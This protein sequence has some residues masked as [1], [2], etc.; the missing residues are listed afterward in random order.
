MADTTAIKDAPG[1]AYSEDTPVSAN[2]TAY[3]FHVFQRSLAMIEH[4]KAFP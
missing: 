3:S 2:T 4:S 1:S